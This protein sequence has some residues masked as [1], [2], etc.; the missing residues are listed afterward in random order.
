MQAESTAAAA[1]NSDRQK[2]KIKIKCNDLVNFGEL[3][4]ARRNPLI[5]R[6]T[7]PNPPDRERTEG[8]SATYIGLIGQE[9]KVDEEGGGGGERGGERRAHAH[10]LEDAE[11]RLGPHLVLPRAPAAV[12]HR[13]W[14]GWDGMGSRRWLVEARL[15]AGGSAR[16]AAAARNPSGEERRARWR[17]GHFILARAS[18][19]AQHATGS[20][21]VPPFCREPP[22]QERPVIL[23]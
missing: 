1:S 16:E 8:A 21:P 14:I 3:L 10:P 22:P 9:G 11:A 17:P 7:N 5:D 18:P 23:Y 19:R 6:R 13:N 12:R 2:R 4:I 20:D 15:P